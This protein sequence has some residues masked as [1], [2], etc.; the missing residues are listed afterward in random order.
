MAEDKYSPH[1]RA[2][3]RYK[4]MPPRRQVEID[5]ILRRHHGYCPFQAWLRTCWMRWETEHPDRKGKS[6]TAADNR[7]FDLWLRKAV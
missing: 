3:C 2:Y 6:R 1:Y 5:A 4:R 7:A